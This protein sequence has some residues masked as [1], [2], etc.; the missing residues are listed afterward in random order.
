MGVATSGSGTGGLTVSF[1]TT[2][3]TPTVVSAISVGTGSP[4]GYKV[5]DL[6]TAAHHSAAS[7]VT[8][9][10]TELSG[11][12]CGEDEGLPKEELSVGDFVK[13]GNDIA[14]VKG[15]TFQVASPRPPPRFTN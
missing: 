10:V 14:K 8:F 3:A 15:V 2:A 13:I 4:V 12:T 5:G 6:V 1:T 11:T 7:T 9:I